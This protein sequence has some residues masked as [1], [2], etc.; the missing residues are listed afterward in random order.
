NSLAWITAYLAAMHLGAVLHSFNPT[1]K[2]DELRYMLGD[3]SPSIV[4][5][6]R[7]VLSVAREAAPGV[8]LLPIDELPTGSSVSPADVGPDDPALLLYTSGTTGRP[9]GALL[10]H[11]NL[12]A[13]ARC[14][15]EA[16]RWEPADRLVLALPL[17]HVHSLGIGLHG[18]L[19]RE[20]SAVLVPFRPEA[21]VH[22]LRAGGTM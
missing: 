12:L 4:I 10:D 2:A 19:L 7:D 15:I 11:G 8:R 1:Y 13:Q 17:F 5:G 3:A 14:V 21:V 16:W 6:D 20:A 22:E 9:K 18:T